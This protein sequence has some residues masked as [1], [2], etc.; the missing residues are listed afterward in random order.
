MVIMSFS[1]NQIVVGCEI[2][3]GVLIEIGGTRLIIHGGRLGRR[4]TRI[5]VGGFAKKAF[6]NETVTFTLLMVVKV[7]GEANHVHARCEVKHVRVG[8]KP[9]D[10]MIPHM[11]LDRR[12]AR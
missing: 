7:L 2:W 4:R 11:G 10:L 1:Y 12:A 5:M 3:F 8:F 9:L 6:P